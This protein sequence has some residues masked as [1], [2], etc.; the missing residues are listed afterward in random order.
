MSGAWAPPP[1]KE[2][3]DGL[4]CVALSS[5]GHRSPGFGEILAALDNT[6]F[7][8]YLSRSEKILVTSSAGNSGSP[9]LAPSRT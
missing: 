6:K 3:G 9:V 8:S 7:C 2:Q 5:P 1:L 4:P